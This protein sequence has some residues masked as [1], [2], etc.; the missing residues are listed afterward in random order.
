MVRFHHMYSY[1]DFD[2]GHLEFGPEYRF[3][4]SCVYTFTSS[5]SITGTS[6]I[7]RSS[8]WEPWLLQLKKSALKCLLLTSN[9]SHLELAQRID[10]NFLVYTL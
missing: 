10:V 6:A 1:V 4:I 2:G 7:R 5:K 8:I 9:G 3:E